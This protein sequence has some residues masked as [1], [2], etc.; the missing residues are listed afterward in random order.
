M[1]IR[2]GRRVFPDAFEGFDSRKLRCGNFDRPD[3]SF[4]PRLRS[5]RRARVL[6][7]VRHDV[8]AP[9]RTMEH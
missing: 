2:I 6:G 5:R 8:R 9:R 3:A 7:N 1:Q 4:C